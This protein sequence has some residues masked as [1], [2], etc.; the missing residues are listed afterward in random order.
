[1]HKKM[2]KLVVLS[3]I[4]FYTISIYGQDALFG[5]AYNPFE[6]ISFCEQS[7]INGF[8]YFVNCRTF[9]L[10]YRFIINGKYY[11]LSYE[12][13]Q[14]NEIG[15]EKMNVVFKN[16][17]SIKYY[18]PWLSINPGERVERNLRLYRLD[19]TINMIWNL[20][21]KDI[22]D[23]DYHYFAGTIYNN[24]RFYDIYYDMVNNK[25]GSYIKLLSNGKIEIYILRHNYTNFKQDHFNAYYH[26]IMIEPIGDEM[27]KIITIK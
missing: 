17:T 27:Y 7:Q 21:S 15:A 5:G 1:M 24:I 19:D 23:N 25:M 16:D 20:A 9:S 13:Y 14:S 22:I 10:T 11:M 3:I 12:P 26:K 6:N 2:K 4:M 8:N 18:R